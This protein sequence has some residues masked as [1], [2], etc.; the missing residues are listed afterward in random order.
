MHCFVSIQGCGL[1]L[2]AQRRLSLPTYFKVT[3]PLFTQQHRNVLGIN[4]LKRS[5][6][7]NPQEHLCRLINRIRSN[8]ITITLK[9]S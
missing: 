1:R 3:V 4:P 5:Q 6:N 7:R 8:T 9:Q 2:F